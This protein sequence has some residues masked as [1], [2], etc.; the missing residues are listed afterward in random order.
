MQICWLLSLKHPDCHGMVIES[1]MVAIVF[2]IYPQ[3][4][5]YAETVRVSPGFTE[6]LYVYV[7][8]KNLG[9]F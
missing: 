9:C 6:T 3:R 2:E 5:Q 1:V 8:N 7:K 4:I